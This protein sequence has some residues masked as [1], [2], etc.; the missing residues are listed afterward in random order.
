MSVASKYGVVIPN[1]LMALAGIGLIVGGFFSPTWI[2]VDLCVVA[3]LGGGGY[4]LNK[5]STKAGN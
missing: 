2:R 4:F 5:L 3:V 1:A